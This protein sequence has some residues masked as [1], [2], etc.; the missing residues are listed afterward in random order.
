M[1]CLKL[2]NKLHKQRNE[3]L[4]AAYAE[5]AIL[6]RR[7][8]GGFGEKLKITINKNRSV[9]QTIENFNHE[10]VQKNKW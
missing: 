5:K 7:F 2:K 1:L 3:A 9:L 6:L 4:K 10:T 8:Q